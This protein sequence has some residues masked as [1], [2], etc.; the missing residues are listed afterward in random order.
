MLL[1]LE[2]A[3]RQSYL[4]KW[5]GPQM[6]EAGA[7]QSSPISEWMA[8]GLCTQWSC[9]CLP[10]P[11]AHSQGCLD[12]ASSRHV[13]VHCTSKQLEVHLHDGYWYA[14]GDAQLCGL[15]ALRCQQLEHPAL[16]SKAC[17]SF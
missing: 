16:H 8:G 14:L 5:C 3:F 4:H 13:C 1:P 6:R 15:C 11:E 17:V 10:A 2:Q 9:Q 12:I 7:H